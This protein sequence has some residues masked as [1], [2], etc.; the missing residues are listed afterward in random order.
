MQTEFS[1]TEKVEQ[2]YQT[3][4]CCSTLFQSENM[5]KN[6]WEVCLKEQSVTGNSF[7]ETEELSE[8]EDES[9]SPTGLVRMENERELA[10]S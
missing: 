8:G 4:M 7:E 10:M 3:E 1:N 6:K 5:Y 9:K 2:E